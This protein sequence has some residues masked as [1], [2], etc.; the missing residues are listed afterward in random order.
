[1]FSLYICFSKIIAYSFY[2][3]ACFFFFSGFDILKALLCLCYSAV[4]YWHLDVLNPQDLTT[5]LGRSSNQGSLRVTQQVACIV[6]YL[7]HQIINSF[8]FK[9]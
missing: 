3:K 1:M 9:K 2:L 5:E 7:C 6:M 4:V 8:E